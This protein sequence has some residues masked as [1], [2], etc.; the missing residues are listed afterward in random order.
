MK[1]IYN[2]PNMKVAELD[3]TDVIL[4]PGSPISVNLETPA[5][6][7]GSGDTSGDDNDSR[8]TNLW[9]QEW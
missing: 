7:S 4:N 6:G 3:L 8:T 1:K 2:T 9:D 5:T